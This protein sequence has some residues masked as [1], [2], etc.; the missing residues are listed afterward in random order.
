MLP[1]GVAM[2]LTEII[3]VSVQMHHPYQPALQSDARGLVST[4]PLDAP[5]ALLQPSALHQ[6]FSSLPH[7]L[8]I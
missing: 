8:G 7:V 5:N 3:V 2:L 1:E 4:C 6:A